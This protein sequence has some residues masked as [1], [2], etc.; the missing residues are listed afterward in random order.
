VRVTHKVVLRSPYL[1]LAPYFHA[2]LV[3][4]TGFQIFFYHCRCDLPSQMATLAFPIKL[5]LAA[6][7]FLGLSTCTKLQARLVHVDKHVVSFGSEGSVI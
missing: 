2:D 4:A 5:V 3:C 1:E 6:S 7:T